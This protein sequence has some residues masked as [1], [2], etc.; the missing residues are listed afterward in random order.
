ML[1]ALVLGVGVVLLVLWAVTN[2]RHLE[3]RERQN[4]DWDVGAE[5]PDLWTSSAAC[6][7]C[8]AHGGLLELVGDEV[9]FSCLACGRRHVRRSR[10]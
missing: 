4:T 2:H 9:T 7:H 3:R 5:R 6:V 1:P 10:S 8:G